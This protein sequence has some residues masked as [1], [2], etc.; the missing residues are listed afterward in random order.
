VRDPDLFA[1]ECLV[2]EGEDL[3]AELRDWDFHPLRVPHVHIVVYVMYVA[4]F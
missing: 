2:H 3:A 1:L 4:A